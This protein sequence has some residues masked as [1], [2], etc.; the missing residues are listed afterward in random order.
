MNSQITEKLQ[1]IVVRQKP[2]ARFVIMS[3]MLGLDVKDFDALAQQ[4][5]RHGGPGFIVDG[6]PFRKVIDGQFY[7]QR[8]TVKRL[9]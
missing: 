9:G 7:I 5:I 8:V 6:I 2:E 3:N 4:W 1:A